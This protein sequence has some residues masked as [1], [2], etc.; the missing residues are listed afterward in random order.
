MYEREVGIFPRPFDI[1]DL[2]AAVDGAVKRDF[3][4]PVSDEQDL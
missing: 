4:R 3:P 1:D 2:Y